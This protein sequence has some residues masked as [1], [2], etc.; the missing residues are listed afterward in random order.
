MLHI[1]LKNEYLI[2]VRCYNNM[3]IEY[4]EEIT[5]MHENLVHHIGDKHKYSDVLQNIIQTSDSDRARRYIAIVCS[6]S[7]IQRVFFPKCHDVDAQTIWCEHYLCG[8]MTSPS[9]SVL[10]KCGILQ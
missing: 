1:S 4:I 8:Y 7:N 3:S 6:D 5:C 9:K 2:D 10:I